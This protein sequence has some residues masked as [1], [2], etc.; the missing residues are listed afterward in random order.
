MQAMSKRQAVEAGSA[1]AVAEAACQQLAAET[2]GMPA[3][4]QRST[5]S[6]AAVGIQR[7]Q[8]LETALRDA[9]ARAAAAE[10]AGQEAAEAAQQQAQLLGARLAEANGQ[11][12][13]L[14]KAKEELE[15]KVRGGGD[16]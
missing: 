1:L 13:D 12:A 16:V 14:L 15:E 10:K 9:E 7:M 3:E 2:N 4:T 6:T 8:Q 5:D 11:K